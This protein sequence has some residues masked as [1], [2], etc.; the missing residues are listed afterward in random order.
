MRNFTIYLTIFLCLIASKIIAQE[1][2]EVKAKIIAEK[3][4]NITKEE[5]AALKAEIES[6]NKE[7]EAGTITQEQAD[8]KKLKFAEVRSQNIESRVG[9]VQDELKD[10]VK[11]KVDGKI[12][13]KDSSRTF[14]IRFDNKKCKTP[15]NESRTTSQIVF[16]LGVNNLVTDNAVANSDFRYWGSH[17]YE[18]GFAS[19][20]RLFKDNNLLHGRYGLSL[21][22]NNLRP[23]D[24]RY[25]QESGKET[26]LVT[27]SNPFKRFAF[28]KCLSSSSHAFRIR[29][30]WQAS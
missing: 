7:L 26:Q 4:E 17:F 1:T 16:A 12:E 10:L 13:E 25:F 21:M 29:F 11:Q 6:V 3:I 24:N 23:T 30:F 27:S 5:K 22:Y 2:F 20:T 15:K 19:S 9:L 18:F 14:T 28:S 8:E